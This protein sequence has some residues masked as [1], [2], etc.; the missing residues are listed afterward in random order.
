MTRCAMLSCGVVVQV[1]L[2]FIKEWQDKLGVKIVCSQVRHTSEL[3]QQFHA[4]A[5]PRQHVVGQG[6]A[7]AVSV[8]VR[9]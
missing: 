1:M 8:L 5:A 2:G 6:Q 7:A 3:L 4:V 9:G